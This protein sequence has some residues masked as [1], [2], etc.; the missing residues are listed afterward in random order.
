MEMGYGQIRASIPPEACDPRNTVEFA[1]CM[2][3]KKGVNDAD[4]DQVQNEVDNCPHTQNPD[5][6][7][8]NKDGTGD[9]CDRC[10]EA[11][12]YYRKYDL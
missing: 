2:E 4:L 11:R 10:T 8:E 7:D 6:V 3:R 5:Q 1:E 9:V 12:E